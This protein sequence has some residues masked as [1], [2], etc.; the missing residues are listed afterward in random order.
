MCFL[1]FVIMR[2]L[3]RKAREN[4]IEESIYKMLKELVELQV[5]EIDSNGERYLL[6]SYI[7]PLVNRIFKALK[8]RLPQSFQP[9]VE[10][11]LFSD[12]TD[13]ILE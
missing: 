7:P 4:G 12:I 11:K 9:V 3:E 8:I 13:D 10:G 2:E 6:R 1:A 5:S